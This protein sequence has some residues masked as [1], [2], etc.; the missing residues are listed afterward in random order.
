M[1]SPSRSARNMNACNRTSTPASAQL[2]ERPLHAF[3]I[4]NHE[5]PAMPNGGGHRAPA[6]ELGEDLVRASGDRLLGF[7]PERI[8]TAIGETAAHGRGPAE[9]SGRLDQSDA[10][11]GARGTYG[12]SDPRR[13]AAHDED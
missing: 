1:A 2:V 4:E 8:E 9:T 6:L 13:A 12:G 3:A 10:G 7:L 5:S 11:A